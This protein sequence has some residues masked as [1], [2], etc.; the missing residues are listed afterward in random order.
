MQKKLWEGPRALTLGCES[1]ALRRL[2]GA[3][4]GFELLLLCALCGTH[5]FVLCPDVAERRRDTR[6]PCGELL[7]EHFT[8]R[9]KTFVQLE[10]RDLSVAI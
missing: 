1:T 9:L 3:T 10:V 8:T 4:R 6:L 7:V 2:R 5:R